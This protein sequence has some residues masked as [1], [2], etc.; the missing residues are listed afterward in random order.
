MLQVHENHPRDIWLSW[1]NYCYK[2][3]L[4]FYIML[5]FYRKQT[6]RQL[7]GLVLEYRKSDIFEGYV[8]CFF[9]FDQ[10]NVL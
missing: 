3:I 8:D 5:L 7:D 6:F 4:L 10:Q 2:K 9:V 1:K